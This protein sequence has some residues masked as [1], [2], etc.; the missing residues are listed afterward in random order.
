MVLCFFLFVIGRLSCW[1]VYWFGGNVGEWIGVLVVL[2][3]C[4][5]VVINGCLIVVILLI[6]GCGVGGVV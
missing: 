4:Y 6:M 3:S 5:V 2:F 1:K